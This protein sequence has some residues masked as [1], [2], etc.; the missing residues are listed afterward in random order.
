MSFRL[1]IYYCAICGGCA[2]FFGWALGAPVVL[3]SEIAK[4]GIKGMFL[5][6]MVAFG[7]GLVDS[8]W[9]TSG[10]QI[11]GVVGRVFVAVTVGCLGGLLGGIIGEAFHRLTGLAISLIFGW[12]ITGLLIGVSLGTFD[13]L[14]CMTQQTDSRGAYR[15]LFNGVLGG[16][17]GGVLGGVLY[18]LMHGA[19]VRLFGTED[20]WSPAATGF[21]ALGM[22]IGLLIGLTQVILKE[23]WLK[24]EAGFRAGRELLLSR[25]EMTIGRAEACDLGLFGDPGVDKVHVRITHLGNDFILSDEGS[26]GGTWVNDQRVNGTL[27]LRSGDLIRVGRSLV[28]FGERQKREA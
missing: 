24:V 16:A 13:L 28:R 22:C 18:L 11:A 26:A 2:A 14:V 12:M 25:P 5:G 20:L 19:W 17:L 10:R 3:Q 9:N 1:F 23:A 8:L 6:M 7:L 21:V 4:A 27:R 15:K